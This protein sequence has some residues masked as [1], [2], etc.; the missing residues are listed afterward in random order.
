MFTIAVR[1]CLQY[2]VYPVGLRPKLFIGT[3]I[4]MGFV[5]KMAAA[6]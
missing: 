4:I 2:G 3:Q 6:M 5:Y 1:Y